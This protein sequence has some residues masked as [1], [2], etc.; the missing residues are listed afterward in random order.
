MQN[1]FIC[2]HKNF[3]QATFYMKLLGLPQNFHT[4]KSLPSA[5]SRKAV[6]FW[7]LPI[8]T[9]EDAS[10]TLL[11]LVA[12]EKPPICQ[13]SL[14]QWMLNIPHASPTTK[15]SSWCQTRS[16]SLYLNVVLFYL[17]RKKQHT[18][19]VS[20]PSEFDLLCVFFVVSSEK[21]SDPDWVC[22]KIRVSPTGLIQILEN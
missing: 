1:N 10:P 17:K 21:S 9:L 16:A 7:T 20:L 8:N 5:H 19:F 11:Y 2:M 4:L 3:S 12:N 6:T 13:T 22:L 18:S 15:S 14:Q